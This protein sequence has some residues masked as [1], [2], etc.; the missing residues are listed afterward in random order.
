MHF[1]P[2]CFI[3]VFS[4][5]RVNGLGALR[6][7]PTKGIPPVVPG[8]TSGQLDSNLH[9]HLFILESVHN[10]C[11]IHYLS[12]L[13]FVVVVSYSVGMRE[14]NKILTLFGVL[15]QKQRPTLMKKE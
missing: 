3:L 11:E 15:F 4:E 8:P 6:K 12:F 14:I 2:L 1:F 9:H 7:T 13:F 10:V 5:T